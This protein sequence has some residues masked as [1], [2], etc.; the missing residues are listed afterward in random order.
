MSRSQ[1]IISFLL[2]FRRNISSSLIGLSRL[3]A[4]WVSAAVLI[5]V[6]GLLGTLL[7]WL[8]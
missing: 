7:V 1:V 6:G 4:L 3:T 8:T 2:V 5:S